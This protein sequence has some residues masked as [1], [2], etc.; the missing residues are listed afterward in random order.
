MAGNSNLQI[1]GMHAWEDVEKY[2]KGP[3][4]VYIWTIK[5]ALVAISRKK[6]FEELRNAFLSLHRP[7]L[8]Q[9]QQL[10]L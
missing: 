6:Y 7:R 3:I 9:A 8:S 1:L 10:S 4:L 2:K 5:G